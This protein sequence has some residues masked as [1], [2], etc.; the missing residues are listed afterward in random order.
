M[1]APIITIFVRRDADCNHADEPFY[2]QCGCWK[3]LRW[4]YNG[5]QNRRATKSKTWARA[6]RVK[7][8]VELS[9][10]IAG[11]PVQRDRPATVRQAVETFFRDK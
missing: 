10:E 5:K 6:E 4:S 1:A 7:R 9:Y 8:E 11:K 2:K 3:H